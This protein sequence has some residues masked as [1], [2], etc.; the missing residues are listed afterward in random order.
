LGRVQESNLNKRT[1][2]KIDPYTHQ[3]TPVKFWQWF[4]VKLGTVGGD[5]SN[6]CLG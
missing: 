4:K 2:A 6:G 5:D 3:N 1:F